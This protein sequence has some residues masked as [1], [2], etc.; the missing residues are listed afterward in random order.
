MTFKDFY[1]QA[2]NEQTAAQKFIAEIA[3]I[4]GRTEIAIRKWL[5]GEN[6]PDDETKQILA[7]HFDVPANEYILWVDD[8]VITSIKK[9][10]LK[11]RVKAIIQ[12]IIGNIFGK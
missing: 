3:R 2:K 12:R 11:E 10:G 8:I 4:T 1:Q 9:P 6:V 5:S 7:E